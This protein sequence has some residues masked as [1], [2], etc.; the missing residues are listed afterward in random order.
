MRL[1]ATKAL[2]ERRDSIIVAT[3]SSIYGLGD[4]QAYLAM[5][6]HLERGD[7]MDQRQ[8]LRRLADMQYTRNELDLHAGHATACAA[9]SSTSS[10]RSRSARRCASSCST[11][12]SRSL[13]LFDPLTGEV[14]RK[15]PRFTVYPGTHYV[16]PRERLIGAVDQI[17]EEL[18]ERL[19]ELREASKL[20][21][22]QRLEQRTLFDLE[23]IQRGRL[24]R[25]HR[26]LLALSVG[27]RSRASRRRACSTTCRR[28]RCWSSTRA[29]R[30][31]RSWAPCT[32]A[33][34]RA[35]RRWWSTASAC[36]RRSTTG[37]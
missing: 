5:V 34:A 20:V 12:R 33:I 10:R 18:R 3:V 7:R 37:R 2:L 14:L 17:R 25:R 32:R 22:A 19:Q 8:L 15:V 9:T 6:L 28:T 13:A 35:R 31:F 29:T 36:P 11:T 4:P 16:T 1:S 23:M 27:A 26:E 30:P 21:E 24:L